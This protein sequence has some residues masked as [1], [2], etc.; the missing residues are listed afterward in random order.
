M[1]KKVT[2]LS[3]TMDCEKE[4]KQVSIKVSNTME[5]DKDEYSDAIV[6]ASVSELMYEAEKQGFEIVSKEI[7]QVDKSIIDVKEAVKEI[8]KTETKE[9]PKTE[10]TTKKNNRW[11][12]K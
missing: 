6:F 7:G 2:Y 1:F 12:I 11:G 5:W 3:V 9:E 4:G 8:A 10:T